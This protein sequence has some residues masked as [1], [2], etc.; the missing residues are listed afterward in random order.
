[1]PPK[2]PKA[3]KKGKPAKPTFK[4]K[5]VT[6]KPAAPAEAAGE[7]KM[8]SAPKNGKKMFAALRGMHDILPKEE[9]YW[10]ALYH[11]AESLATYY[12]FGRLETPT[13]EEAGLFVRG[14]G[15]GT[16][17]VD[18]EMYI[19]EDRDGTRVGMR[20]EG[21]AGAV[22]AYLNAGMWNQTQPIKMWYWESMF[23][24]ERPQAGRLRE[25]HQVGFETL[26][27][28][29]PAL[30]AELILVAYSLYK[31]LGLLT[32]VH[33]NTLG[34]KEERV[35]YINE[36]TNYYRSKRA[37]LCEDCKVRLTKNP[38]RLLDCK[39]EGCQPV[40]EGAP[41]IIDWL[42]ETSKNYFMK[43][44]EYLDELGVPYL[45]TPTL[46]RG[47]D[48]YTHTVFEL[49]PQGGGTGGSQS[50]LGGGGR[51]DL[52]IEELGGQP[53]PAA[54]FGMGIE[55]AV[56]A[57]KEAGAGKPLNIPEPKYDIFF[58]QLGEEAKRHALKIINELRGTGL[59]PAFNLVKGSL[60]AQL[61]TANNL[62]VPYVLILGQ[63]EVQ[64]KTI[65][66]RD[67]ESGVQEIVDQKKIEAALTKKL[68]D[69]LKVKPNEV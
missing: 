38:M 51:Y 69:R 41:Q 67:M 25:H 14:I 3:V 29:D 48:Y 61:E 10:K 47:L 35:R 39:V 56:Y 28:K 24:H 55:R 49:Y 33:I 58:A 57:L 18:K 31:D 44:L 30:D 8:S 22:R 23:R 17:V 36:L 66:I 63:K 5:E 20:P 12:Q 62:K 50:A 65:I 15:R 54:G 27:A 42:E 60:K 46:V 34:T 4:K 2:K 19:F 21:T 43:V 37:Y 45:L 26:G 16:D 32:E 40:K 9:K 1:M 7:A 68:A 53:A 52:L 11:S 13:L 64:D 6:N 59:K